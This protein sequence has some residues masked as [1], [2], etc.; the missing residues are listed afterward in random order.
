MSAPDV[1]M[2]LIEGREKM[3]KVDDTNVIPE[4]LNASWIKR[5]FKRKFG[6]PVRVGN[7]ASDRW[8]T[9]WIKMSKMSDRSNLIYDHHFPPELGQ[10]C[11]AIIYASSPSLSQQSWGGNIGQHSISMFGSQFRLLL[12][13]LLSNPITAVANDK[14]DNCL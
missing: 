5:F 6:I 13:G 1:L 7:A 10:R 4:V 11:M 12:E 2:Y 9:V 3:S 14:S 8:V